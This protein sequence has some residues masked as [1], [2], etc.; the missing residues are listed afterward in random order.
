M[1][2]KVALLCRESYPQE[3]LEELQ[4]DILIWNEI[5]TV[6]DRLASV[7]RSNARAL[8]IILLFA[9]MTLVIAMYIQHRSDRQF[10]EQQ[11]PKKQ[12]LIPSKQL[13]QICC[14]FEPQQNVTRLLPNFNKHNTNTKLQLQFFQYCVPL[15]PTHSQALSSLPPVPSRKN[16]LTRLTA[17]WL[18][19]AF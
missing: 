8:H 19:D 15:P 2:C 3:A 12:C 1:S 6:Q 4:H 17:V 14:K 11:A 10:M 16:L 18:Q 5:H 13:L 9:I 7:E